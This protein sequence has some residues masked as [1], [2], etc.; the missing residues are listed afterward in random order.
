MTVT[1]FRTPRPSWWTNLDLGKTGGPL[2]HYRNAYVAISGEHSLAGAFAYDEMARMPMLLHEIGAPLSFQGYPIPLAD[3]HMGQTQRWVQ[4]LGLN[5]MGYDNICRAIYELCMENKYHPVRD[6][7]DALAW[8]GEERLIIWLAK[9]LGV[10]QWAY[11]AEIG[12]RFLISMVARIYDPGCKCDHMLV[13]EGEQGILKSTALRILADPWFSDTLPDITTDPKDASVHLRGKWLIEI[14]EMHVFNKAES[15][16]LK[17]FIS[18][19]EE[20][21]RPPFGRNEVIEPR[22]CVFAGTTNLSAYLKDE[23]GGRRFWPVKCGEEHEIRIDE[24][25]ADRDQL[26]A[27]AVECYRLSEPWHPDAKFE[28]EIIRPEQKS[29]YDSDI[30]EDVIHTYLEGKTPPVTLKQIAIGCLGYEDTSVVGGGGKPYTQFTLAEQYRVKRAL[31]AIGW[32]KIGRNKHAT[33]YG[34][35]RGRV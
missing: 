35:V 14:A 33:Q 15:T 30:L 22:Q 18:R 25:K 27:E 4:E 9:Y 24:L 16:H 3:E 32:E 11:P 20:R 10:K 21:F 23:T 1:P 8:D 29:R 6:Y 7:L 2:T 31:A 5:G 13:L 26:F 17:S 12:K 34:P 19:Q 28:A